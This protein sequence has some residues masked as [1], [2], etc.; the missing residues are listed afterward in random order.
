MAS[1]WKPGDQPPTLDEEG[2]RSRR[3]LVYV[4]EFVERDRGEG[5]AAPGVRGTNRAQG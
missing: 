5:L 3:V 1:I 2:K 4:P